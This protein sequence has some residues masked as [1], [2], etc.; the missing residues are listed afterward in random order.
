M[1]TFNANTVRE[2]ARLAELAHC[3]EERGVEILGVQEHR[4]VHHDPIAYCRVGGCSFITSSAWRNKAQAAT[5]GVGLMLSSRVRRALRRAYQ[6]TERILIANFDGNPVTTVMVVYSP[7]NVALVED[8]EK[9]YE[10]LRTAIWDVPTH[11]FLAVLGDFNARLGPEDARFTYH[12]ATNRNG[13]HLATLLVEHELLAAN[14]LFHK[15]MGK[16]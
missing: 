10:D 6:H 13:E 1:G 7:T 14:T 11:N 2:D 16:R 9:F 12:D 4:R 3:A 5:G 15:R 8:V